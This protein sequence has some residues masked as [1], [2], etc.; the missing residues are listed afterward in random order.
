MIHGHV[1]IT[2]VLESNRWFALVVASDVCCA[3]YFP[4]RRDKVQTHKGNIVDARFRL[5][6]NV[7][8]THLHVRNAKSLLGGIPQGYVY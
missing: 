7:N 5:T 6:P 8:N 3:I 1:I 2:Y 4:R